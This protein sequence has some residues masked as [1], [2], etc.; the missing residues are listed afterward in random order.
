MKALILLALTLVSMSSLS[1]FADV[2]EEKIPCEDQIRLAVEVELMRTE[3][4]VRARAYKIGGVEVTH[5]D[6]VAGMIYHKVEAVKSVSAPALGFKTIKTFEV[7][8][9]ARSCNAQRITLIENVQ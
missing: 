8:L 9:D 1:A 2:S 7:V 4:G 3:G 6:H 5:V